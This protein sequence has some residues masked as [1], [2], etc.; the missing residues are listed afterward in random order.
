MVFKSV[1]LLFSRFSKSKHCALR[2]VGGAT[3]LL[4][5]EVGSQNPSAR[6]NNYATHVFGGEYGIAEV[7]GR[8]KK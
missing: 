6:P 4:T 7:P 5:G 3:A 8:T 1:S 2:E